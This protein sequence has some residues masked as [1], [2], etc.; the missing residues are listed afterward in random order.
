MD[1]N[2]TTHGH[3]SALAIS[4][5]GYRATLFALGSLW[6][7]NELGLLYTL[8]RITAVS[9][10][11][12]MLGYLALH[13]SELKFNDNKVAENFEE[14][15]AQPVQK[16]C[17]EALDL[18][19][20]F[21]GLF[22]LRKTIGDKVADTYDKKL[23]FG[24]SLQAVPAGE[25][26]PEF[27]FYATNYD[28]GSSV[29]IT[30]DQIYD[31]KIGVS[32]SA[33]LSI[34]QAVGASSAFPP[35]FSPVVID[36]SS[37]HWEKTKYAYLFD[38]SR[39]HKRLELCDGGLY[40]NLGLEAVWKENESSRDKFDQLLVC[41][42]GAPLKIGFDTGKGLVAKIL[43]KTGLKRNWIAQLNRMS[44]IMIEQQR[45]LRKRQLI[46]N[47]KKGHY[48]GA[49]WG[50]STEIADY[51]VPGHIAADNR[52][53]RNLDGIPTRLTVFSKNDRAYLINWGYALTDAAIR[54]Y[55]DSSVEAAKTLPLP[56]FSLT[57][58]ET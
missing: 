54:K 55:V 7:L 14:L 30:R 18:K 46:D 43:Q 26:V 1:Q 15:I 58:P 33:D 2:D 5:G 42:A 52:L 35:V 53:T 47:Y 20:G 3:T 28:T 57:N 49:Y 36:S 4:G 10:G 37:W 34:A 45:A 27:I 48:S 41:D 13:W 23:F 56:D 11:S 24:K 22:S 31:Y 16:F 50:I 40:D 25:S 44:D 21:L 8:N 38:D 29:R 17:S 39:F 6:R 9:G 19:A 12:I 51:D 32:S